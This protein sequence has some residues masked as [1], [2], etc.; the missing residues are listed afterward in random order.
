[1]SDATRHY[2]QLYSLRK[3]TT[4][5]NQRIIKEQGTPLVTVFNKTLSRWLENEIALAPL[6]PD[7]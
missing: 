6:A 2:V 4:D 7:N 3:S 1:M 5:K